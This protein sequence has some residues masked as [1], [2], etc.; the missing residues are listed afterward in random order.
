MKPILYGCVC[1]IPM[2]RSGPRGLADHH[3]WPQQL[4]EAEFD[5]SLKAL[6]G[7]G[8]VPAVQ[9]RGRRTPSGPFTRQG[10]RELAVDAEAG[11]GRPALHVARNRSRLAGVCDTG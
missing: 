7:Y 1:L 2:S 11:D 6:K 4:P 8:G 3:P 5:V 10:N 9:V